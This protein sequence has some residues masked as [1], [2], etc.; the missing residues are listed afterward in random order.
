MKPTLMFLAP[1]LMYSV[2]SAQ[3][4][5]DP[6]LG[7]VVVDG[8]AGAGGIFGPPPPKM[9]VVPLISQSEA[10]SIVGLV[11][12]RDM[13]L[14][15]QFQVID[16]ALA[17]A[18]P[19]VRE[20]PIEPGVWQAKDVEF[21]TRVYSVTNSTGTELVAEG[22][23]IPKAEGKAD[24]AAPALAPSFV[25]RVAAPLRGVRAASHRLVDQML[26]AL[27]GRPGSFSSV[28]AYTG[29]VGKWR[30]AFLVD[31]DGF[32]LRSFGPSGGT[33]LSPAF[34][35]AGE[36]YYALSDDFR[37]FRLVHGARA[38]PVPLSV[39][40][41][42]LGLSFS[43]DKKQLALSV[44]EEG[45]SAIYVTDLAGG[46]MRTVTT[47][48][49][50][51]HPEFGPMN[52]LAWVAGWAQR[53]YLDGKPIGASGLSSPTFC[54]TQQGLYVVA[55]VGMGAGADVLA[56][57]TSGTARRL[58]QGMAVTESVACS[59][60]GRLVAFFSNQR[61]GKG[62]GLYVV[63]V[64]RPWLVKKVSSELGEWLRWEAQ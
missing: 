13:D 36:L 15:G 28:V 2:A 63:P 26:G 14:S 4:V 49:L 16:D 12:R 30:Q 39:R 5:P 51:N 19:H 64:A 8:S 59:P 54:D 6:A 61:G 55:T 45:K 29:R 20:A 11:V 48:V 50:A 33:V 31:S 46:T 43:Q 58:T 27:T 32:N 62:P 34:G 37:R 9:A 44:M 25:L 38:Q 53:L 10:D 60:D 21:V 56:F 7:T 57:D 18:G 40:G 24:L 22:F 41:S 42:V 3:A 47:E 17:P 35:P 23:L 52:K 1:L